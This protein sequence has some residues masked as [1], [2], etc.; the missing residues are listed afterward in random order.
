MSVTINTKERPVLNTGQYE[1]YN[2][3]AFSPDNSVPITI[4]NL[5]NL[6]CKRVH[7]TYRATLRINYKVTKTAYI[8][9]CDSFHFALSLAKQ[10]MT[11]SAI[12]SAQTGLTAPVVLGL[13]KSPP[14]VVTE[15]INGNTIDRV[16]LKRL[17]ENEIKVIANNVGLFLS[18]YH[19][20]I[21]NSGE[22]QRLQSELIE[23]AL[24]INLSVDR[25]KMIL[26][27]ANL[28][29]VRVHQD[30]K[31][32]NFLWDP[33]TST[34]GV[35]DPTHRPYIRFP[36]Y[37][38]AVVMNFPLYSRHLGFTKKL[39]FY[40]NQVLD[41]YCNYRD[42][43]WNWANEALTGLSILQIYDKYEKEC[44]LYGF[45]REHFLKRIISIK[46]HFLIRKFSLR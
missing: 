2:I 37:D 22:I 23:F 41:S 5:Y 24:K 44:V 4:E 45:L 28:S 38:L 34:I 39:N 11:F 25:V 17:S 12:A 14:C 29:A 46:R 42:I 40:R 7:S 18:L 32:A 13:I 6:N 3:E 8:K 15:Q 36:H 26:E 33:E 35:I 10:F 21:E 30:P 27:H 43:E 20:R 1:L 19:E 31:P 16:F 9:L